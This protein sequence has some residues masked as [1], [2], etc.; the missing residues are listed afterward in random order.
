VEFREYL[1]VLRKYWLSIVMC[2]L[3]GALAAGVYVYL[4]SPVYT[5]QVQILV[6]VTV[7]DSVGEMVQGSTYASAQVRNLAQIVTTDQILNPV[8]QDLGLSETRAQLAARVTATIPTNTTLIN[9][10]ARAGDAAGSAT[11]AQAV[12]ESLVTQI[13]TIYE[14]KDGS[15]PTVAGTIMQNAVPPA[16]PTSPKTTQSLAL[17]L[18]A[19]LAVGIGL[20]VLRK[21]LD[22]RFHT[23]KDVTDAT[24]LPVIGTV[25]RD[26]I[27]ARDAVVMLAAP[28]SGM[29][30]RYR[31]LRTNLLFFNVDTD[32][33][34]NFV[35]T[36]SIEGEGKSATAI[37]IA[38]A[39]AEGGERVLLIDADLRRP[40]VAS[41]LQMEGAAGLTT[42]L[43]NRASLSD[44]VQSLGPGYPDVLTAG[45]IPPNPAELIGSR[46]MKQLLEQVSS[47]Y[48]AVVIDSAPLLPV[49][50]TLSLL[51]HVS[52]VVM[53]TA[54]EKVTVPELRG[55]LESIKRTGTPI[56]GVVLNM[57]RRSRGS[58][59]YNYRYESREVAAQEPTTRKRPKRAQG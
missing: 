10:S 40:R 15:V 11:L 29:A 51:P 24:G 34:W 33:P 59:Y 41:Y 23:S 12:A 25:P 19:G 42:V 9:I 27:I 37:N 20:A 57:V 53:V 14:T 44:V 49:A 30:E 28:T 54:A 18:V 35:V 39:L 4:A 55:A 45:M 17:G 52:G 38:Y 5:A 7:G 48:Q 47:H 56:M 22:V 16:S 6:N 8:I 21:A 36:S 13:R 2:T 32:K 1:G 50:D 31:Q 43:L 46:R 58:T 26:S 3:L